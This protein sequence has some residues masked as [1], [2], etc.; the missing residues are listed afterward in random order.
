M[1]KAGK[2]AVEEIDSETNN[3]QASFAFTLF[4]CIKGKRVASAGAL[5][6]DRCCPHSF[7]FIALRPQERIK[8]CIDYEKVL[9]QMSQE[10]P[11]ACGTR[12]HKHR[13]KRQRLCFSAAHHDLVNFSRQ[14]DA[15][16]EK[17]NENCT[18]MKYLFNWYFL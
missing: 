18:M 10:H 2:H 12:R 11:I 3:R 4:E 15:N 13:K 9:L 5:D 1:F 7:I 6:R 16:N 14:I 8:Y 17:F